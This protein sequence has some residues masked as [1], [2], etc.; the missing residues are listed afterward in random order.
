M[1]ATSASQRTESSSAFLK[2]PLLRFEN[3][4]CLAVALSIFLI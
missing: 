4:T 3:V 1:R 2:S